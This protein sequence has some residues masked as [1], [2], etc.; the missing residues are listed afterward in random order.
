MLL[1]SIPTLA[2]PFSQ[3]TDAVGT[4]LTLSRSQLMPIRGVLANAFEV[5]VR[6]EVK[7]L[8]LTP[9]SSAFVYVGALAAEMVFQEVAAEAV[10][11]ALDDFADL[12]LRIEP[13][14]LEQ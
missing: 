10:M 2:N 14:D 13:M 1:E 6:N 8:T 12:V 7:T 3:K 5:E 4:L 9:V 11:L